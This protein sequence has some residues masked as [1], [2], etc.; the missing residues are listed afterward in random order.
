MQ[1]LNPVSNQLQLQW[2]SL[3]CRAEDK[4]SPWGRGKGQFAH[5]PST[6]PWIGVMAGRSQRCSGVPKEGYKT[7]TFITAGGV[8]SDLVLAPLYFSVFLVWFYIMGLM[9]LDWFVYR[10]GGPHT[11]TD[12]LHAAVSMLLSHSHR[13]LLKDLKRQGWERPLAATWEKCCCSE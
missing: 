5:A 8:L 2:Q 11:S 3:D 6:K 7:P 1:G 12:T 10:T 9:V 13:L 4:S